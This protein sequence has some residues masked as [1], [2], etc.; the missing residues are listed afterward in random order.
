VW[1]EQKNSKFVLDD[2]N[3]WTRAQ[4]V[5]LLSAVQERGRDWTDISMNFD[6]KNAKV[7]NN[8]VFV[9]ACVCVCMVVINP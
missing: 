4:T 3:G 8:T 1:Y 6:D 5:A 9:C 2:S 7:H